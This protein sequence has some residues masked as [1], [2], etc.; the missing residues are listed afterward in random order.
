MLML[1]D[2]GTM[3]LAEVLEP[4]IFYA[5]R[6]HP[7][8]PRA[9]QTI[10]GLGDFFST[11]WPTSA[12]LWMQG[13]RAPRGGA[14]FRNP[15]LAET[16]RRVLA[17]SA[18]APN[19]DARI[20][21]ARDC[22]YRGFV[23]DQ[24][25]AFCRQPVM[26]ESGAAHAGVLTGDDMAGYAA[27]W[28]TPVTHDFHGWQIAKAGPW[29]QGPVFLQTLALL[30][31]DD[32]AAM[33]PLGPDY[34]HLLTEAM[35]LAFADRETY[36]GDP[37]F[38]DIPVQELLS[39]GYNADRRALIGDHASYNLRPGTVPGF[40][41]QVAHMRALLDRL[42]RKDGAVYEPTMAHLGD[43]PRGDTVH[44]DVI[45]RWGNIVSVTPSGGWL[46]SSPIVPGLGFCLN[47]RAQ[48]FWLEDGAPTSLAPGRRPRTTLTP[49]FAL[50]PDGAKLAFGTPGGD[51]QDQWQLQFFLRHAVHGMNLQQ[52]IDTPV[53]HT[54]HFPS[55][56][57]PRTREPGQIVVE[58]DMPEDTQA[59]LR[60]RGHQVEVVPA[61]SA[62]RLTA[63]RR[64]ADG[65]LSVA[66]T[67]R[68][69]QAWAAGR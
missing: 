50:S 60:A 65:L 69:G 28:E 58:A 41:G 57:Y 18:N 53:I 12:A 59:S 35:K 52:A 19:R 54:T 37:D 44:L 5:E 49:G 48:M 3:E 42:S 4:A 24:I 29:T 32:L 2:H 34:L 39:P 64:D 7:I 27:H 63:A 66:A 16:W 17:E 55:S 46:Q 56:F 21:A 61:K 6:G 13:G 1:R 45:D 15:A 36:Y 8:L 9:A 25:D 14:N 31:G 20:E 47:S 23:A 11:H 62:A 26:D 68:H 10:A 43:A 38:S 67:E 22:F 40:D 30:A 33:D 51:Q